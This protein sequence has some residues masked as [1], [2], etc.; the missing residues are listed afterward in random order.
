MPE[1]RRSKFRLYAATLLIALA[2]LEAGSF[3]VIRLS[4]WVRAH[5]LPWGR[6]AREVHAREGVDFDVLRAELEVLYRGEVKLQPYRWYAIPENFHGT[7]VNTDRDGFRL[8]PPPTGEAPLMAFFGGST[9]FSISTSDAHSIPA[10]LSQALDPAAIQARNFGVGGYSSSAELP[11]FIEELRRNRIAV[12]V[13]YDGFNEVNTYL[14]MLQDHPPETYWD[15]VG[16]PQSYAYVPAIRNTA[17]SKALMIEPYTVKLARLAWQHLPIGVG[18]ANFIV[19]EANVDAHAERAASIYLRNLED[20]AALAASHGAT[21]VF[22]WQPNIY[23]TKKPLSDYERGVA[24][25]QPA[26]RLLSIALRQKVA[27]SPVLA[28]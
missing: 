12:A 4:Y 21:P 10:Y 1:A 23:T 11:L 8:S 3:A 6:A 19:T 24:A 14:G 9:I 15:A 18:N 13:F 22:F 27:E 7:Y 17:S 2:L 5:Y 20:I 25:S 26:A 16:Y 28:R